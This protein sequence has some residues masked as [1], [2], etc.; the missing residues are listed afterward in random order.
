VKRPGAIDGAEGA[1]MVQGEADS[2]AVGL[3]PLPKVAE[4]VGLT[5]ADVC[6]RAGDRVPVWFRVEGAPMGSPSSLRAAVERERREESQRKHREIEAVSP[7]PD[8]GSTAMPAAEFAAVADVARRHEAARFRNWTQCTP[9]LTGWA[10][11]PPRTGDDDAPLD[12]QGRPFGPPDPAKD[13]AAFVATGEAYVGRVGALRPDC[14]DPVDNDLWFVDD[15]RDGR[16]GRLVRDVDLHVTPE[17]RAALLRALDRADL[18]AAAPAGTKLPGWAAGRPGFEALAPVQELVG[19]KREERLLTLLAA[20]ATLA[21]EL[22]RKSRMPT[23]ATRKGRPIASQIATA[24]ARKCGRNGGFRDGY[25]P[26]AIANDLSEGFELLT[27]RKLDDSDDQS[28]A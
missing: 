8:D 13:A 14:G 12:S 23:L 26:G 6:R 16:G 18:L 9:T 11:L 5:L 1:S 19:D 7:T 27:G 10:K 4:E 17:G 21:V 3:I 25:L 24:L 20:A 2:W 15:T 28:P 22:D